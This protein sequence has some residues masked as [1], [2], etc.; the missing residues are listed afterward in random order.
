MGALEYRRERDGIQGRR[1]RRIAHVDGP[2][3]Q[4][5]ITYGEQV[6]P[7]RHAAVLSGDRRGGDIAEYPVDYVR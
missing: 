3:R 4:K 1:R 7:I 2:R 5:G 6:D